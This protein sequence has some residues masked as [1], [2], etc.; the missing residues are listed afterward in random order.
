MGPETLNWYGG[1]LIPE[2]LERIHVRMTRE[3]I[4]EHKIMHEQRKSFNESPLVKAM[5]DTIFTNTIV[6]SHPNAWVT[7]EGRALVAWILETLHD[8][9]IKRSADEPDE[10]TTMAE[11]KSLFT[12]TAAAVKS[13]AMEEEEEDTF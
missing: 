10:E 4:E 12:A 9:E 6:Y 13:A 8:Y 11:T 1:A 2:T 3:R 5:M 7:E